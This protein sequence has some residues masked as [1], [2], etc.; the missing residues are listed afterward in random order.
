MRTSLTHAAFHAA[1]GTA[2]KQAPSFFA[3][4]ALRFRDW[5]MRRAVLSELH[6]LDRATL[7]D[8]R[9]YPADF[10]AIANGTYERGPFKDEPAKAPAVR[11][12]VWP[13]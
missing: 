3:T 12:R 8:L 4:L 5:C 9:I 10:I 2:E 6:R 7:E 1:A 11:P 13:L